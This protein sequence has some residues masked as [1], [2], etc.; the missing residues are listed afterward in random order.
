[1]KWREWLE[2]TVGGGRRGRVTG[3]VLVSGLVGAA[4]MILNS[5]LTLQD[6]DSIAGSREPPPTAEETRA[7]GRL[8][9]E[10]AEYEAFE[11]RYEAAIRDILQKIA[12]VGEVD[13][14]VTIDSTEE[15]VVERHV[16]QR[17]QSTNEKDRQ[18]GT[19]VISDASRS[20]QVVLVQTKGD[21]TPIV[22]KKIR[23]QIRGVVVVAAGAENL[24]VK[25]LIAEAVERGLGVPAHRISV[26]PGKP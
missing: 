1:M 13:V 26:I 23:P 20:G 19:R 16:E 7:A 22:V 6:A 18:G 3:W 12:G 21:Q 2:R 8:D 9:P 5:Y 4:A 10:P 15:L 24:T 14:M 17:Q 11:A 25:K